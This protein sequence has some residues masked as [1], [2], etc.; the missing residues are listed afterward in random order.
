MIMPQT[1]YNQMFKILDMPSCVLYGKEDSKVQ[2][3]AASTNQEKA[4]VLRFMTQTI[5][6]TLPETSCTARTASNFFGWSSG[7]LRLCHNGSVINLEYT[8]IPVLL[9]GAPFDF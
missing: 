4:G 3:K 6:V 5:A 1:M 8:S 2:R 9:E 7:G